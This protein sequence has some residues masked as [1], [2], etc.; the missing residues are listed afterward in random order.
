MI[1]SPDTT[2]P[3]SGPDNTQQRPATNRRTWFK[4][5]LG[6][7]IGVLAG[8]GAG[9]GVGIARK[10]EVGPF[11]VGERWGN[12]PT[13]TPSDL[14]KRQATAVARADELVEEKAVI[15]QEQANA[16]RAAENIRAR[17][18]LTPTRTPAPPTVTPTPTLSPDQIATQITAEQ[19]KAAELANQAEIAK[20]LTNA[21]AT[22]TAAVDILNAARGTPTRTPT[23]TATSTLGPQA[24]TSATQQARV[25]DYVTRGKAAATVHAQDTATAKTGK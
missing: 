7:A 4:R 22:T 24:A 21:R 10:A 3:G 15:Q 25:E 18:A 8:A 14:E 2:P 5:I 9:A 16:T 12:T 13:P 1:Q 20:Q 11:A 23:P 6:G 17:A 19:T